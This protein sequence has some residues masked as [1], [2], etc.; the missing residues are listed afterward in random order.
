M[1]SIVIPSLPGFESMNQRCVES[2][3]ETTQEEIEIVVEVGNRT[4]AENVNSGL[5]RTKG[6]IVGIVN[7]DV[8]ALH[9]WFDWVIE[10]IETDIGIVSLTPRPDCGWGFFTKR[11]IFDKIGQF[12]EHLKNSYDD[13]DFFIRAAVEGYNRILAPK[14]YAIHAGGMTIDTKWGHN[15]EMA[16]ERIKQ[17]MVNR[18]YIME[19]WP[20]LNVD[21]VPTSYWAY[22]G[23]DLMKE[24]KRHGIEI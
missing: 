7:N 12:D 1:I 16:P 22:H 10:A 9:G 14:T 20:G 23:V 15:R 11:E 17:C 2:F 4:F 18:E 24:Y 6:N 13:Y 3:R 19:K 8:I 21:A 5:K